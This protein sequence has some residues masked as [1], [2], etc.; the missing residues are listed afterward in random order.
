MTMLKG[1]TIPSPGSADGE[2]GS[3]GYYSGDC[4]G[5]SPYS[6]YADSPAER[7]YWAGQRIAR[8]I[9]ALNG[10]GDREEIREESGATLNLGPTNVQSPA[11]AKVSLGVVAFGAMLGYALG[12]NPIAATI[13]AGL[14]YLVGK[15]ASNALSAFD[16]NA[17]IKSTVN[18][19]KYASP[20]MQQ[21]TEPTF[22]TQ[23]AI[24]VP[25]APP[26]TTPMYG[27]PPSAELPPGFVLPVMG[28]MSTQTML[29]LGMGA[30][31]AVK[32]LKK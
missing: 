17:T 24:S 11:S 26:A 25:K 19:P 28:G 7:P 5:C 2:Y 20:L 23:T 31:V 10:F 15:P 8:T 29:L 30:L 6:D 13:G 21:H 3:F 12:R 32:L 4:A 27:P 22:A 14:G 9:Q 16:I 18:L 1:Y